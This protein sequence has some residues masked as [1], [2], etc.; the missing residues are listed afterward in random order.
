MTSMAEKDWF[1]DSVKFKRQSNI[2]V[3]LGIGI[4]I[5][6]LIGVFA[7]GILAVGSGLTGSFVLLESIAVTIAGFALVKIGSQL[8]PDYLSFA[9]AIDDFVDSE[10]KKRS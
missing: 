2:V 6:G 7:G 1:F 4:I 9:D 5:A 3:G 8:V 10:I